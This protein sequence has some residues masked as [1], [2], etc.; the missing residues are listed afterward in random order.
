[1]VRRI[2]D[3]FRR[4]QSSQQAP[5][6][7]QTPDPVLRR[8][9]M[10]ERLIAGRTVQAVTPDATPASIT[11]TDGSV[12][13]V[14]TSAPLPADALMGKTVQQV[15]QGGLRLALQFEGGSTATIALAEETSSVLLRDAKG[16]F[17]YA[18]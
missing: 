3:L 8:N 6:P 2:G 15:R 4:R 5:G 18:D 9:T 16:T 1:M 11:F 10:L 14:K 17:E 12:M 13:K 7:A